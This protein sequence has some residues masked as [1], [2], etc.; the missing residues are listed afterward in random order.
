MF[1]S[2]TCLFRGV[3]QCISV[4]WSIF[5]VIKLSASIIWLISWLFF[6]P[7]VCCTIYLC[8]PDW[9]CGDFWSTN[10]QQTLPF[11]GPFEFNRNCRSRLCRISL[12]LSLHPGF[13]WLKFFRIYLIIISKKMLEEYNRLE[14]FMWREAGICCDTR[15]FS[16]RGTFK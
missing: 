14:C 11:D 5:C 1:N 2:V 9:S 8:R 15:S 12:T 13:H 6:F 7:G 10:Q 3:Y 16:S 4:C